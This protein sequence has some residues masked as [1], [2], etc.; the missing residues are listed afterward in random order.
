MSLPRIWVLHLLDERFVSDADYLPWGP[1]ALREFARVYE[2]DPR[3]G[4]ELFR[5][6]LNRLSDIKNDVERSDNSLRE[7]VQHGVSEYALRRWLARKLEERSKRRYTIPQEEEIDQQ[8]RPDLRAEN[9]NTAPVSVELKWADNWTLAQL[10]E[11][12]ENQLVGQYL[13]AERSRYG[14]YLLGTD[15]RKG[16]WES[17]GGN[18]T[19]NQVVE[20]IARRAEDLNIPSPKENRRVQHRGVEDT[21]S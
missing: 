19:F 18:L 4:A 6:V 16:H 11:R 21:A 8:E 15:G 17:A 13:R 9:P 7:E 14:I 10:L 3:T 20:Q 1:A 5:I 2:T 12:L